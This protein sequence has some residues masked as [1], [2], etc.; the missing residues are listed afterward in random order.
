MSP[1][2]AGP[3]DGPNLYTYVG[4]DPVNYIDPLGLCWGKATLLDYLISEG[5]V[6]VADGWISAARGQ[7]AI[8]SKYIPSGLTEKGGALGIALTALNVGGNVWRTSGDNRLTYSE[9]VVVNLAHQAAGAATFGAGAV[10]AWAGS[11][12]RTTAGSMTGATLLGGYVGYVVN[13]L[14]NSLYNFFSSN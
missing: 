5:I 8:L 13:N 7:S 3:V 9:K 4:N 12:T 11:Y 14:V 6:E 2:P 10:G 1:D